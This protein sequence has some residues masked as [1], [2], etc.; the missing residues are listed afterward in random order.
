M[1]S[2]AILDSSRSSK[3][4]TDLSVEA[5]QS[6]LIGALES[7]M[8]KVQAENL[9]R[10]VAD[11]VESQGGDPVKI[12]SPVKQSSGQAQEVPGPR[13]T[14]GGQKNKG[15]GRTQTNTEVP[16]T[17]N[18][19]TGGKKSG[20]G[21]TRKAD[22]KGQQQANVG[23]A[24]TKKRTGKKQE[25]SAPLKKAGGDS[26]SGKGGVG[27]TPSAKAKAKNSN[28]K[29]KAS[30]A[31][32][33]TEIK[34]SGPNQATIAAKSRKPGSGMVTPDKSY[35]QAIRTVP[36]TN[37]TAGLLPTSPAKMLIGDDSARAKGKNAALRLIAKN[38]T[39]G[40]TTK[41]IAQAT[42]NSQARSGSPQTTNVTGRQQSLGACQESTMLNKTPKK[43]VLVR[44][45]SDPERA[46]LIKKVKRAVLAT[47]GFYS[48]S[49]EP[50]SDSSIR[51]VER[52]R[53]YVD[54]DN[55]DYMGTYKPCSDAQYMVTAADSH[56]SG[57]DT[58]TTRESDSHVTNAH[59]Q[60]D[61]IGDKPTCGETTAMPP[62]CET[63]TA[64][65]TDMEVTGE[66]NTSALNEGTW[67]SPR[68]KNALS[69]G[70]KAKQPKPGP[71]VAQG[72]SAVYLN[73]T[74]KLK[75]RLKDGHNI[76]IKGRSSTAGKLPLLFPADEQSRS[77]LLKLKL[78]NA[79]FREA[80]KRPTS[81]FVM[82]INKISP[83][84][85]DTDIARELKNKSVQVKRLISAR[86]NNMPSHNVKL[87]CENKATLEA[88]GQTVT[89]KG[90]DYKVVPYVNKTTKVKQCYRC[91]E[92][93][94]T[95]GQCENDLRCRKCG[96]SHVKKD[97]QSDKPACVN[98]HGDHPSSYRGCPE[99]TKRLPKT[100]TQ[101]KKTSSMPREPLR[102]AIAI[103]KAIALVLNRDM[104]ERTESNISE[105]VAE[106]FSKAFNVKISSETLME[107][108]FA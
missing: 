40:Q 60:L 48:E 88:I 77:R 61:A 73:D 59:A 89:I 91:L 85:S 83:E 21:H 44:S 42:A 58:I 27:A 79:T 6:Q 23:P 64:A 50:R 25:G 71:V 108:A 31:S 68:S 32:A 13:K 34:D 63:D 39:D 102:L 20:I 1:N 38:K 107:K 18:K 51:T 3:S 75:K 7:A 9:L 96:G 78:G 56:I 12:V 57:A 74:D 80:R 54:S 45:P 99:K 10:L 17:Q 11:M 92:F 65:H 87:T 82:V 86:H 37:G 49:D 76:V 33:G 90:E 2:P 67:V 52:T 29:S 93:G 5:Q 28:K 41:A 43:R 4:A 70:K 98:C 84:I 16:V 47:S 24:V 36:G 95:S 15:E 62:T 81:D 97:C 30:S 8:D 66:A 105:D 26:K 94:H 46:L 22:G 35:A 100:Q 72:L 55:S 14:P 104:H 69:K 19:E 106:S 101:P 103:A 53:Y